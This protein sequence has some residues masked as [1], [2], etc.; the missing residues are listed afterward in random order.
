MVMTSLMI[1]QS[2]LLN[3][4]GAEDGPMIFRGELHNNWIHLRMILSYEYG[5]RTPL[6]K[7]RD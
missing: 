4:T 7:C 5:I 3:P 6:T 2:S 1:E